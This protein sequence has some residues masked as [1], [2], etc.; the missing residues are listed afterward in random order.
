MSIMNPPGAGWLVGG[1]N[2]IKENDSLVKNGLTAN[3]YM[4]IQYIY[5]RKY[6]YVSAYYIVNVN[7][8]HCV[9]INLEFP[10]SKETAYK[11]HFPCRC[12]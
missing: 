1:Y 2:Y 6:I 12:M 7:T 3:M 5:V 10:L 11:Y 9:L 4:T 8:C